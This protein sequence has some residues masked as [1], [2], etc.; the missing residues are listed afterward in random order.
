MLR[1]LTVLVVVALAVPI[2]SPA[3]GDN[4]A[5]MARYD[6]HSMVRVYPRSWKQI[7][8]IHALGALLMSDAE[9]IG[10]VDYLVSPDA[11][12]SLAAMDLRWEV[13]VENVQKGIDAERER[14][15]RLGPIDPRGRGW[16]DDFKSLDQIIDKLEAWAV[17][18]PDLVELID[19]GD[20]IE[21]RDIWAMRLT[22]PGED[23]PAVLFNA[24]QHAREWIAPMVAMYAIDHLLTQYGVD[25]EITDLVDDVE[26]FLIPVVNPDGYAYSWTSG[27]RYWRKNRRDNEGSPCYGVDPNRNWERGWGGSG[28]SGDP[29]SET[30]RGTGPFSEPC[31]QAMEAFYIAHPNLAA[32]IDFHSHG[33]YILY[34]W[35]YQSGPCGDDSMHHIVGSEMQSLIAAVHGWNYTLGSIYDDLYPA[36]GGSVDWSW[37][38]QGVLSYT[39]ELRGPDFVIPPGEIIPNSEEIL[40]AALYLT[41]WCS[42]PVQFMFPGGIP[43]Q[44]QAGVPT[45]IPLTVSVFAGPPIEEGTEKVFYRIGTGGPFTDEPLTDLGE[46]SYEATL[47]AI[48]AGQ[49]IQFYFQV[50]TTDGDT[51]ASPADAPDEVYEAGAVEVFYE[52]NMSEDPDWTTQGLWAYGQPTGG[53]GEYGG[54]DPTAGHTGNKVFGYNLNGDYENNMPE[55]HLT[56]TAIDCTGLSNVGLRFYRWLGVEQPAYDHA[57]IRVSND[58]VNWTTVWHNSTEVTDYSWKVQE[59][60]ISEVADDQPTVYLRWTMG[61]SDSGWRYCGWNI[62]DVQIW[63]TLSAIPGDI[64]G[65]GIVN[66][67]DLLALLAAWGPCPECPE[68]INGDGTVN[69][70]DLLILLANWG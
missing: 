13:L 34:P 67:E 44:V 1:W 66:T 27:N 57:Y 40:P 38:E 28:S 33:E 25:P 22:G 7:E 20:S 64:N 62:D 32:S 45:T 37:G 17:D 43:G 69:T 41:D 65:D 14:L 5:R 11:M 19:I 42:S 53:G 15:S 56:S 23:K 9:G 29:C 61:T 16:F 55:R 63:A 51:Y 70:S 54:P 8:E 12:R 47:P 59:V 18:Y 52:W 30:Y 2:N 50:E 31:T 35:A 39:I 3:A 24:T 26:I 48:S 49:V 58:G 68:D 4:D 36:A 6:N 46:G 21:N 10:P 60:D